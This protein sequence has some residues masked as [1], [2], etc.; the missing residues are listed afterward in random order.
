[1][2]MDSVELIMSFERHFK[3][4]IPDD[5]SEEIVTV[6]DMANWL[7]QQLGV[8]GQLSSSVRLLVWGQ[9]HT[10]LV[11]DNGKAI[12]Y[13]EATPLREAL[14]NQ[15]YVESCRRQL[16]SRYELQMPRLAP[17]PTTP[18]TP[19][20]W[21]RIW[22]R[23]LWSPPSWL[24]QTLAELIDWLVA[25][26]YERLLCLPLASQYEVEQAV[27]GIT[28]SSSG[29]EIEAVQLRSSFTNDLGID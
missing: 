17:V 26:N 10:V 8:A 14:P 20:L 16:L 21:E 22:G 2:G 29:V 15:Q 18:A 19:S 24:T 27:I 11:A 3:L 28:S 4:E 12:L 13:T 6:G 23:S 25:T 5:V 1:M 7:S 9:L